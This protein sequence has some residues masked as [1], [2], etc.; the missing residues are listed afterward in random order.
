MTMTFREILA[1][2]DDEYTYHVRSTVD[3]HNPERFERVRMTLMPFQVKTISADGYTPFT[4]DNKIFP[5]EPNSPTFTIKV[6]TGLPVDT[7]SVL[8]TMAMMCHIHQSHLRM[9]PED[10]VQSE[11]PGKPHETDKTT[12][13]SLVGHKRIGEF[14]RELQSDRKE[15]EAKVITREVY[16]SFFTTHRALESVVKKPIRKGYYMVEMCQD[17]DQTVMRAKGPFG[18]RPDGNPYR[19]RIDV[20]GSLI[21]EDTY[22]DM[23]NVHV[24]VE[25]QIDKPVAE[26]MFSVGVSDMSS[27]R[28]FNSVVRAT[29]PDVAR[30]VAVHQVAETHRIDPAVLTAMAPRPVDDPR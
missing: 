1:E 5:N 9:T 29:T 19:D 8:Q 23:Y 25:A 13:Q 17:G 20:K 15:R 18:N 3:I 12:A 6:V 21:Y 11:L 16:E 22:R 26:Q 10:D 7:K 2:K 28:R 14:M 30:Q 27:G 24:L 4:K